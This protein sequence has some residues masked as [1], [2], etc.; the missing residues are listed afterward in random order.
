MKIGEAS[1]LEMGYL[2]LGKKKI[3]LE[4]DDKN[5]LLQELYS[6]REAAEE[7]KALLCPSAKERSLA[8]NMVYSSI[9]A[10]LKS[11]QELSGYELQKLKK[12]D[13]A[14]YSKA[15]RAQSAREELR[16]RLVKAKNSRDFA[17]A[18]MAMGVIA[19]NMA[20]DGT[21]AEAKTFCSSGEPVVDDGHQLVMG[22]LRDEY[23]QHSRRRDRV[24]LSERL[25]E[26]AEESN[27]EKRC[28]RKKANSLNRIA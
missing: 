4:Q 12:C 7:M 5:Q 13:P 25:E 2:Q 19:A 28:Q 1:E 17:K 11:G 22:A 23:S 26:K 27:R 14:M 15:K 16:R 3:N 10:K 18:K 6:N 8:D 20:L 24:E 21:S 9:V